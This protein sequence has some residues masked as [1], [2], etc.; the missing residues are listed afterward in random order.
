MTLQD[1]KRV[2][3]LGVTGGIAAYKA[4]ELCS[5]LT[6][7]GF[8]VN[9][10]MTQAACKFVTPL[11]FQTLS[12]QPV[13]TSLFEIPDWRPEHVALA[14][15]VELL[16][17]APATA[18][19]IGKMANG[20]ADDALS[21][22]AL[23]HAGPVLLAPAMNPKMWAQPVVQEN[24]ERLKHRGVVVVGPVAGHVACGADGI[25]RMVESIELLNRILDWREKGELQ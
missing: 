6:K 25:G 15:R 22:F 23:T 12:R 11:T 5:A 2:I 16:V 9:V 21:T 14:D 24:I 3:A 10:L 13:V 17:V 8:E 19:F 20:I 1:A 7:M 4:A 18:D